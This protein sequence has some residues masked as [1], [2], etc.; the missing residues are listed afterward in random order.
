METYA[1]SARQ[2]DSTLPTGH[3]EKKYSKLAT[4][5]VHVRLVLLDATTSTTPTAQAM[6]PFVS[7]AVRRAAIRSYARDEAGTW[8]DVFAWLNRT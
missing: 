4:I 2:E 7:P 3:W 6:I 8:Q 1:Q 5:L